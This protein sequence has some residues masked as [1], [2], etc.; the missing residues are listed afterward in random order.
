MREEKEHILYVDDEPDNLTVF[1]SNFR[2][3]YK[4]HTA[5]SADEGLQILQEQDIHI[6]ITD[7][8]MPN[9]TGVEFLEQI[10]P[11]HPEPIRMILTGFSD[12]EAIIQ[13][14]NKGQVYR[15]ITKPWDKDELKITIDKALE[16][17]HLRRENQNLIESLKEANANLEKKVEERTAEVHQQKKEIEV[18]LHNIL[19]EEIAEELKINGKAEPKNYDIVSVL[20]TDFKGFTKITETTPPQE[21]LRELNRCFM[22]FDEIVE[23]Y[24]LEKIK[25]IGDA[26]MCA[27]GIPIANQDNPVNTV[28]AALEMQGF[29]KSWRSA[30]EVHGEQAWELRLGIHTGPLIAGVIGKNKFAYDI[31]GDTVNIAAR[32]E[33]SGEVGKVNISGSTYELVKD[34]Y[35]CTYRGKIK[36]KNKGE[37]DMYFVEGLK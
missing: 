7:Q 10:M 3:H 32:M 33:S 19:P 14:I 26:Y 25:T 30:K 15:Y 5:L 4:V 22:A 16:S 28:A 9:T 11:N 27:G 6:V 35:E 34:K 12:V 29:M 20:F 21:L 1:K 37:V 2:R 36:A 24:G 31:W 17:F 23:K 18:L 8:R 13:A